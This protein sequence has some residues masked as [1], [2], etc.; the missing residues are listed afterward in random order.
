MTTQPIPTLLEWCG[1]LANIQHLTTRFYEKVPEDSV[2]APVFA[3]MD[4]HHADHVAAFVA[5][6]FGSEQ[7]YTASGGS[8]AGMIGR[9]LGRHLIQQEALTRFRHRRTIQ[10]IS[11]RHGANVLLG[12][13][14]C[15]WKQRTHVAAECRDIQHQLT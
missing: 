11:G 8:H 1:G 14:P 13:R 10:S 12:S 2:L 3:G 7:P 6:I 9:H 4:P 15:R 5:E